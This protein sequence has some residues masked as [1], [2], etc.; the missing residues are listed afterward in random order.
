LTRTTTDFAQQA[1]ARHRNKIFVLAPLPFA[2]QHV[3]AIDNPRQSLSIIVQLS[4]GGL[5][6]RPRH[7]VRSVNNGI[8][9]Q[10]FDIGAGDR[11][12]MDEA[13]LQAF[14]EVQQHLNSASAQMC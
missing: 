6:L 1:R 7:W 8:V 10:P 14:G 12:P 2:G 11:A 4:K 3:F 5:W 9:V 13:D